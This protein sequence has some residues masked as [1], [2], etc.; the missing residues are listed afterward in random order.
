MQGGSVRT[1][2]RNF[3]DGSP[4]A[5]LAAMACAVHFQSEFSGFKLVQSSRQIRIFFRT[6][7]AAPGFRH[8]SGKDQH[9]AVMPEGGFVFPNKK[10]AL[11]TEDKRH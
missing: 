7:K 2:G 6:V 10:M 5:T 3:A 8:A 11:T 9:L 1:A 4:Q